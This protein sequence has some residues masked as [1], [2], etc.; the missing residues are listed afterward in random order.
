MIYTV[1]YNPSRDVIYNLEKLKPGA[2]EKG[3]ESHVYPAGKAL[4]AARALKS[5]GEDVKVLALMAYDDERRFA[6]Y[7]SDLGIEYSFY[8]VSGGVRINTTIHERSTGHVNH[9]NSLGLSLPQRME[10]DFKEFLKD[11]MEGDDLW[12]FSGSL[13]GGISEAAYRDAVAECR[14]KGIRTLLD[15][16]DNPLALGIQAL[17]FIVKPNISELESYFKEPVE[18]ISHIA[19]KGKRLLDMGIEYVFVSLGEDGVIALNKNKC[20]LCS[21][22]E[23]EAVDTVGAGDSFS[24]GIAAGIERGF[25]FEEVCRLASACGVASVLNYG[26]GVISNDDVADYMGRI[27]IE[28]V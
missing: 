23:V 6:S 18:G 10:F 3:V 1:L 26:P 2:T 7:L 21:V 19:L 25:E 4:N 16:R 5:L 14:P 22:P 20:L 8:T 13:P 15:T 17:P 27:S 11:H 28:S 9:L 24:A 12:I